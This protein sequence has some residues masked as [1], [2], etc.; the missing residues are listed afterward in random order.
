MK[1]TQLRNAGMVLLLCLAFAGCNNPARNVPDPAE[2]GNIGGVNGDALFMASG[3][4]PSA[5]FG[6]FNNG[7]FSRNG[8]FGLQVNTTICVLNGWLETD[9]SAGTFQERLERLRAMGQP[10]NTYVLVVDGELE[11]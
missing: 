11:M 8:D 3:P 1:E 10:G 7:V 4:T 5:Q 9:I 6:T 2:L